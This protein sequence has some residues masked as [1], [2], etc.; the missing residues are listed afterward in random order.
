MMDL[1]GIPHYS[2]N[3]EAPLLFYGGGLSSFAKVPVQIPVGMT[4]GALLTHGITY[5][6]REHWFQAAK[7]TNWQEHAYVMS[8]ASPFLAKQRGREINLRPGWD[9][10]IA[11]DVM[12]EGI[13]NQGPVLSYLKETGRRFIAEDSPTD[14]IWGIRDKPDLRRAT[15]AEGYGGMNLLGIALMQAR[16]EFQHVGYG[17]LLELARPTAEAL[18]VL[19]G[20]N[21]GGWWAR[22][23][24]S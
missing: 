1:A 24:P 22:E 3:P 6:S 17:H 8:A 20:S 13:R 11:Y 5:D 10:G 18:R 16:A 9:D 4:L 7:A 12:I 19:R 23:T 15:G 2:T 21:A 14:F